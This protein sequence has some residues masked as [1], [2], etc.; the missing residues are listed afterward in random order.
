MEAETRKSPKSHGHL[1]W[2]TQ[3]WIA[4]RRY[5]QQGRRWGCPQISIHM[6]Q[7][8]HKYIYI[9]IDTPC[10]HTGVGILRR[11]NCLSLHFWYVSKCIQDKIKCI[12]ILSTY[13][14]TIPVFAP[15]MTCHL[16]TGPLSS[17]PEDQ[18]KKHEEMQTAVKA[19]PLN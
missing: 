5:L 15:I 18:G 16:T 19:S 2:F 3:R 11:W 1:T 17:V 7:Y 9:L 8:R 4:K 6:P 14:A 12:K 13:T 10:I